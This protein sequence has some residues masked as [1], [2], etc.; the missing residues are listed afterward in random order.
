[1]F[2]L[3]DPQERRAVSREVKNLNKANIQY[4]NKIENQYNSSYSLGI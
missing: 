4:K 3:G 1:M 2:Y